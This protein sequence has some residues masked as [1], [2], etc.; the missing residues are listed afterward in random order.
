M[1]RR[2]IFICIAIFCGLIALAGIEYGIRTIR[3]RPLDTAQTSQSLEKTTDSTIIGAVVKQLS[4]DGNNVNESDLSISRKKVVMSSWLVVDI[5]NKAL[6][7][8]DESRTMTYVCKNMSGSFAVVAY[9]GDG[10][11]QN[12]FQDPV[13]QELINEINKP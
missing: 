11:S 4:L 12:S 2:R 8:E 9:S 7:S 10:F 6:P 1:S 13:P 3:N 5:T